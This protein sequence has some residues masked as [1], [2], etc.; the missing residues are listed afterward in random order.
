M[1]ELTNGWKNSQAYYLNLEFC[2]TDHAAA[3]CMYTAEEIEEHVLDTLAQGCDNQTTLVMAYK[4]I[5]GVDYQE[6][7][8]T[9][10]QRYEEDQA[11]LKGGYIS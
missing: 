1:T 3:W 10:N 7:V 8:D 2:F 9:V 4:Y 11:Y 6:I 5:D